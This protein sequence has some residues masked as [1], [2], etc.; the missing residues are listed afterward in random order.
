MSHKMQD[1]SLQEI[2][3]HQLFCFVASS[4]A[5]SQTTFFLQP[6]HLL[7]N[8]LANG[9]EAHAKR[10]SIFCVVSFSHG[11]GLS[12]IT[13]S[14]LCPCPNHH[15]ENN[16]HGRQY[17]ASLEALNTSHFLSL[18]PH[19][20]GCKVEQKSGIFDHL[21]ILGP[22]LGIEWEQLIPHLQ[23]HWS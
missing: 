18:F 1:P 9:S 4:T 15:V 5:L 12:P 17:R 21:H 13:S 6:S 22:V 2:W 8:S 23:A 7:Q 19:S 10:D 20:H 14:T 3:S 16:L 11:L